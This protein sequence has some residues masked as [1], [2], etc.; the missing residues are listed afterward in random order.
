MARRHLLTHSHDSPHTKTKDEAAVPTLQVA[1]MMMKSPSVLFFFAIIAAVAA[2]GASS[3]TATAA[4]QNNKNAN[5]RI[6]VP[7]HRH[8]IDALADDNNYS[9]GGTTRQFEVEAESSTSDESQ[10][11]INTS[12][13]ETIMVTEV[14]QMAIT[15][16]TTYTFNK[17]RKFNAN[18]IHNVT[19]LASAGEENNGKGD[20]DLTIM[21]INKSNGSVQ[22]IQHGRNRNGG[23]GVHN[24]MRRI[25]LDDTT[26]KLRVETITSSS[27]DN[28]EG[29][30]RSADND[31]HW[32]CGAEH[33]HD[34]D[35][36]NEED[37][38]HLHH[39]HSRTLNQNDSNQE[40]NDKQ[41]STS[42]NVLYEFVRSSSTPSKT[43]KTTTT[44]RTAWKPPKNYAYHIPLYI[45]I[46]STF[47]NRQGGPNQAIE[48]VNFLTSAVNVILEHEVDAHLEVVHVEETNMYDEITSTSDALRAQRLRNDRKGIIL[49]NDED[50]ILVHAL[51]GRHVGGGIAYIDT[52][53]DSKWGFG[54]TSDIQ[55]SFQNFGLDTIFDMFY[56]AHELGHSLGSGHTYDAYE[57]SVDTCGRVCTLSEELKSDPVGL[58]LDNSATIMSYCNFC[59]GGVTNVAFTY[60]GIWNGMTPRSDIGHWRN[61]PDIAGLGTVSVE[62]RRVSHTIWNVLST[63][64]NGCV[65]PQPSQSEGAVQGCND[66][67]DCNDGNMCTI[68]VCGSNNVCMISK[69][70]DDCCGNKVCEQG[71]ISAGCSDCGPFVI[72]PS[73]PCES[74]HALDGFLLKVGVN[75]SASRAISLTSISIQHKVPED[76]PSSVEVFRARSL[77]TDENGEDKDIDHTA[78]VWPYWQRVATATVP[79]NEGMMEIT[80]SPPIAINVGESVELYIAAAEEILQFGVGAYSVE[81][82]HGVKLHSSHAVSGKFGTALES[83]S[84]HCEVK[85]VVEEVAPLLPVYGSE[86]KNERWPE[87]GMAL[88]ETEVLSSNPGSAADE[89]SEESISSATTGLDG[90]INPPTIKETTSVAYRRENL[91]VA[92]FIGMLSLVNIYM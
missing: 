64:S 37:V 62:P 92:A 23:G 27:N 60:G 80:L 85:Y 29:R 78:L 18:S 90:D 22:G 77:G 68:D 54:I 9:E 17:R 69:T 83:F 81:N 19:I 56:Y 24:N 70:L 31:N 40:Q 6:K 45:E 49:N 21:S 11:D 25:L 15:S 86:S 84:L 42:N 51:L 2:V 76:F 32:S 34:H 30:M 79:G 67:G 12:T 52:I 35:D 55:G 8:L 43:T 10:E 14:T 46:D 20:G 33:G 73:T 87:D 26:N 58:P 71:E 59:S 61:H 50:F 88:A 53:C 28:D 91:Y 66:N 4:T 7:L 89:A 72:K 1:T 41:S 74:C 38:R 36:G 5:K 63:K 3:A 47:I 75:K 39:H 44:K 57:P 65:E 48:Y 16:Q 13:V 82:D